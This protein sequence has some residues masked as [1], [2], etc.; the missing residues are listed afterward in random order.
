MDD[1][2]SFFGQGCSR[3]VGDGM[4]FRRPAPSGAVI[5]LTEDDA[6]PGP[7][8]PPAPP[9]RQIIRQSALRT[10][11]NI[12][13]TRG[14]RF[15]NNII[16]LD[17]EPE[18]AP[19][20]GRVPAQPARV[21]DSPE[22]EFI[23]AR[24]ID[25]PPRPRDQVRPMR[26]AFDID[27]TD[28]EALFYRPDEDDYA[29]MRN[30][31]DIARSMAAGTRA[32]DIALGQ[33]MDDMMRRQQLR[34]QLAEMGGVRRMAMLGRGVDAREPQLRRPGPRRNGNGNGGDH[35]IQFA[36]PDLNFAAVGWDM[37]LERDRPEPPPPTYKKPDAAP[38]GFTR[39]PEED[40]VLVCP[41]CED[42]LCT[43]VG[44]LKKQVWIIKACGHVGLP[45]M[46]GMG[47]I[48]TLARS[49]VVNAL[50]TGTRRNDRKRQDPTQTSHLPLR[51][52][53]LRAARR[54]RIRREP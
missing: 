44:D 10:T 31:R 15:A 23:S 6:G 37:G 20:S 51:Y 48:L 34:G 49:T 13:P 52:V 16:E 18:P 46:L 14:P 32:L 26:R 50:N 21:P 42:E 41:N 22:V 12:R 2:F 38:K 4:D 19:Q 30:R 47:R 29:R 11:A 1:A 27:L 7:S 33:Q 17:D 45:W 9:E 8:R 35:I 40:E 24:T 54:R 3:Y 28:E 5:D 53:W 36:A 25:P 39:S 43:G